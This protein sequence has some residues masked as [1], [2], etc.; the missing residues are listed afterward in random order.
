[1]NN[2]EYGQYIVKKGDSLYQISK[3]FNTTPEELMMLNNLGTTMIY[4]N[5]ILLVPYNSSQGFECG[6][7][8]TQNGDTINKIC[9]KFN[10]SE[11]DLM[12]YNNVYRLE[13]VP[14][15]ILNLNNTAD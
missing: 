1:M 3:L 2:Y 6:E 7:Y 14:N 8:K 5:Q 4:P 13:L 9:N 11:S 15:Q 10:L 12:L